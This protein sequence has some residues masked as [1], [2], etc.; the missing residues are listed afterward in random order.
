MSSLQCMAYIAVRTTA[1][2]ADIQQCGPHSPIEPTHRRSSLLTSSGASSCADSEAQ[3]KVHP[4]QPSWMPAEPTVGAVDPTCNT[5]NTRQPVK[6]GLRR[7]SDIACPSAWRR[8]TDRQK[9][10]QAA[11]L[12]TVAH[13]RQ[14]HLLRLGVQLLYSVS[15]LWPDPWVVRS[16]QQ[17]HRLHG[18]HILTKCS[19]SPS[20]S[21]MS[22]L[23]TFN[24]FKLGWGSNK[25]P[26][27]ACQEGH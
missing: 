14:E 5:D 2:S 17:Q 10:R 26:C 16:P 8:D 4:L 15:A 23:C 19:C 7:Y 25:V 22:S 18:K 12:W 3:V 9:V 1:R 11:H 6:E 24:W 21:S 13:P 20:H 27:Q